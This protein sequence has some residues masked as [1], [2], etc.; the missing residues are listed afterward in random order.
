VK[1]NIPDPKTKALQ[2]DYP[3][4]QDFPENGPDD[5]D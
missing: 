4:K 3:K 2:M 1:I 5:S